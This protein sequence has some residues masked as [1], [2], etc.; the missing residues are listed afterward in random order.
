[1]VPLLE[2]PQAEWTDFVISKY[3]DGLS[4]T[5]PEYAYTEWRDDK[6]SLISSM[7]YDH[8]EDGDE[9]HNLANDPG[10]EAVVLELSKRMH[11]NKG[12]D[13]FK[14]NELSVND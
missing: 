12:A 2:D 13:Y 3:F 1:M 10:H 14:E 6:D 11:E 5:T 7:L 4:I 9:T 8:A